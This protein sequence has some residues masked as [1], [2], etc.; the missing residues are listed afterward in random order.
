MAFASRVGGLHDYQFI[1]G[2]ALATRPSGTIGTSITPGNNTYGSYAQILSAS[3]VA[4][5][6][7]GL[8]LMFHTGSTAAAARDIIATIGVDPA[9]GTSYTDVIPHLLISCADAFSNAGTQFFFPLRIKAGSTVACKGSVNNATVGTFRVLAQGFGRPRNEIEC[10]AGTRVEAVGVVTASSAGT[11]VTPGTTSEG[12]WTDLGALTN[13]AWWFQCA[14][15]I[16]NSAMAFLQYFMDL[17]VGDA[18]NKQILQQDILVRAT[19]SETLGMPYQPSPNQ[20]I[21]KAGEHL[22]GRIQ[23]SGTADSGISMAA[24][25][26]S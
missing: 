20:V 23:C 11:A 18:S 1:C 13:D 24:Y 17:S 5:D 21:A 10:R 26:L 9:G 4:N 12:S 14:M 6:L 7:V 2:N 8:W 22:Y 19:G 3:D 16:N 15:G 25:A